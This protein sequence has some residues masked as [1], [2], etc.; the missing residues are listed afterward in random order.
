VRAKRELKALKNLRHK[1]QLDAVDRA[2]PPWEPAPWS[3]TGVVGRVTTIENLVA[4]REE[5]R[6][7][8]L[9]VSDLHPSDRMHFREALWRVR[10]DEG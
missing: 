4:D 2:L 7:M 3:G 9:A 6:L 5:L 8:R 10:G 1:E